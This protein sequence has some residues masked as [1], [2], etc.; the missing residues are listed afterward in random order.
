MT[1]KKKLMII[2]VVVLVG[3]AIVLLVGS[4]SAPTN[5]SALRS[6]K[7]VPLPGTPVTS[8][9]GNDE[10]S[11]LLAS[12]NKISIDTSLFQNPAYT[13]LRDH[14]VI[15]G[16]DIVGRVNPFAPIGTDATAPVTAGALSIQTI[17][18]GKITSTTVEFSAQVT[19]PD[20]TPVSVVFEYGPTD[21]FGFATNPLTI[22]KSGAVVTSAT[23][24]LPDTAYF[25]RAVLLRGSEATTA[26]TMSFITSKTSPRR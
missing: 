19:L 15:L 14:P 20:T 1:R 2:L 8:P 21:M 4:Q 25:V 22:S 7:D 18:P 9:A 12:I 26:Q 10:F 23:G 3:G 17:Q 6:N 5:G 16:T 13:L 11:S 24:L